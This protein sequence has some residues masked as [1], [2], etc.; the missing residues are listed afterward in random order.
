MPTFEQ[1]MLDVDKI[2]ISEL[3]IGHL[4]LPDQNYHDY[5]SDGTSPEEMVEEVILD[6]LRAE[7]LWE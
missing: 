5:F 1:W 6:E 4:D 7:G 2:L 3:G